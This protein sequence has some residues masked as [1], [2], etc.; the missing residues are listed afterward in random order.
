MPQNTPGSQAG[1][2]NNPQKVSI[3]G[4]VPIEYDPVAL[5]D[6]SKAIH[7]HTAAQQQAGNAPDSVSERGV[8]EQKKA[9]GIAKLAALANLKEL[10]N[11]CLKLKALIW[12]LRLP[13]L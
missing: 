7:E 10:M 13:A 8:K 1:N 3:V 12:A 5:K 9:N 2:P 11:H 6:I 4:K